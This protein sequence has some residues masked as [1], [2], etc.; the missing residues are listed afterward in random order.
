MSEV[1]HPKSMSLIRVFYYK[2]GTELCLDHID[3]HNKAQ[4]PHMYNT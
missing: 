1:S 3:T 2:D 4:P